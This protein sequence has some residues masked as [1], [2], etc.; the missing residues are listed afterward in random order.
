MV[1]VLYGQTQLPVDHLIRKKKLMDFAFV[2]KGGTLHVSAELGDG[3]GLVF[4]QLLLVP[5]GVPLEFVLLALEQGEML[6]LPFERT[7]SE[8]NLIIIAKPEYNS[9]KYSSV[10]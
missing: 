10:M 8:H 7:H 5:L 1:L 2:E 9:F 3:N 4:C 6:L